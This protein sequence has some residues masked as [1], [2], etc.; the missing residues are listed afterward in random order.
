MVPQKS[1]LDILY[2]CHNA[3]GHNEFTRWY[4]FIK[5][6]Y[7]SNILCQDFN[8]Y[9]RSCME[10]H[11]V[12]LKEPWYVN[13]RLPIPQFPMAFIH[14]DLLGPY[15]EMENENQY[16]LTIICML[17][18]YVFMVLIKT[19]ATKD[20]INTYL[21]HVYATFGSSKCI[22]GDRGGEFSS[23]QFTWLANIIPQQETQ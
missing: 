15:S 8:K 6:F 11:E 13:L 10:Y 3:L 16:V 2:V 17:T 19:K 4:A 21:K 18:N 5:R 9:V 12:T 22:L 14:V 7:Y 23:K 1:Q 20:I